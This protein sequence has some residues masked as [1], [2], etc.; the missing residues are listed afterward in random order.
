MDQW[1]LNAAGQSHSLAEAKAMQKIGMEVNTL[2][3]TQSSTCPV[4][5]LR[6]MLAPPPSRPQGSRGLHG[7]TVGATVGAI[8]VGDEVGLL[9]GDVVGAGPTKE[10]V[11]LSVI[12]L[13]TEDGISVGWFDGMMDGTGLGGARHGPQ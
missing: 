10:S 6:H 5:P 13:G 4:S 1:I 2:T 9:V 8:V 3:G 11:G 12:V 7:S